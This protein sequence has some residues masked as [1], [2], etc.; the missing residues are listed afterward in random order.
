VPRASYQVKL[1]DLGEAV[2]IGDTIILVD[3]IKQI[4]QK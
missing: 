3:K 1:T 4:K 2:A